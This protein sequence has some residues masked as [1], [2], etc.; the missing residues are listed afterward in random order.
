METGPNTCKKCGAPID[1]INAAKNER[2][3]KDCFAE[4]I[5]KLVHPF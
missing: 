1:A 3:C 2:M 4:K 5:N